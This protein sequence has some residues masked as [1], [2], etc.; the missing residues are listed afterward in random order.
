MGKSAFVAP[1]PYMHLNGALEILETKAVA[2]FG[3]EAFDFF[4]DVEVGAKV[5]IYRSHDEAEP[6]VSHQGIYKGYVG[7]MTEMRRL[8]HA[9]FRPPTTAGERWAM[10]WKCSD[11]QLLA[12]PIALGDIQLASGKY[13]TTYPHGPLA[14]VS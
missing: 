4:Q 8:E 9:G 12:E 2:L 1:V 14:I 13:M 11:I 10:Y 6:L 3:T 5:L 7:N